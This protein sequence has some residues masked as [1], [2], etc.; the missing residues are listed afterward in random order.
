[1]L[2]DDSFA[3]GVPER[4]LND[5]F[6]TVTGTS[7]PKF[8]FARGELPVECGGSGYGSGYGLEFGSGYGSGYGQSSVSISFI[9]RSAT[10][11]EAVTGAFVSFALGDIVLSTTTDQLGLAIFTFSFDEI[12]MSEEGIAAIVEVS[13]E[14]FINY[15]YE[16]MIYAENMMEELLDWNVAI[17]LSPELAENEMRIVL[18]WEAAQDLD[19]YTLQM[20][21]TT[22]DIVCT[23]YFDNMLGCEGITL[24]VDSLEGKNG[25]ETITWD[26]GAADPYTY[27]IYIN[28]YDLQGFSESEGR[29]SFYGET[30]VKMEVEDGN[31]EDSYWMLGSFEPSEGISSFIEDG[32]LQTD[33]P[34]FSLTAR[35]AEPAVKPEN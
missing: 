19:I 15:S 10:T 32:S 14:T 2:A 35:N 7:E 33:N 4:C 25:S 23:T 13:M 16:K 5:C 28:D 6:Y 20:N 21:K 27:L 22:G 8:C 30:V 31:N 24:D 18:S 17:A 11:N 26:L 12:V 3:G 9:V 29:I 34:D 1:L